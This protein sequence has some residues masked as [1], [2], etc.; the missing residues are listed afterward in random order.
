MSV[1]IDNA[2]D[3]AEKTVFR[4]LATSLNSKEGADA[5]RGYLPVSRLDVWMFSSGGGTNGIE[6]TW[7]VDKAPCFATIATDCNFTC[8]FSTRSGAMQWAGKVLKFLQD[9]SNLY[10]RG[11]VATVRIQSYPVEPDVMVLDEKSGIIGW[12]V[13]IPAE[14]VYITTDTWN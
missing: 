5:F 11:N 7:N 9:T 13:N 2:W 12:T 14:L 1:S 4:E 10:H 6:R 3:E 8:L